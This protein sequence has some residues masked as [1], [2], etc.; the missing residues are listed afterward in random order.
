[1]DDPFGIPSAPGTRQS[2][3]P[4]TTGRPVDLFRA[5]TESH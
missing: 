1:M 4:A 2:L 3:A 5:E